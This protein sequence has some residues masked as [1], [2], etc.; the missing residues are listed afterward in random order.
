M[1]PRGSTARSIDWALLGLVIE[2]PGYGRELIQRFRPTYGDAIESL[3]PV[4]LRDRLEALA[5]GQ[6]IEEILEEASAEDGEAPKPR[7]RATSKGIEQYQQ[8]LVEQVREQLRRS[9][10]FASQLSVLERD[11]AL[12]VI[13]RYE[14]SCLENA[15]STRMP[16]AGGP[17]GDAGE[18]AERLVR[19][20]ERLVV[21]ARLSWLEYARR[22]LHA[23]E[24]GD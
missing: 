3:H 15:R 6:L 22:E 11:D 24:Y 18:L 14:E 4:Q 19:E 2:Q 10:L 16:R 5:R 1:N 7:Y 8:W 12:H 23:R 21:D 17:A 20:E 13:D 9:R